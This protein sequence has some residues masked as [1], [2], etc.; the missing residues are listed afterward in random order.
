MKIN[1]IY[2]SGL[3]GDECMAVQLQIWNTPQFQDFD[4]FISL[5]YDNFYNK[6][7]RKDIKPD[8][9]GKFVFFDMNTQYGVADLGKPERFL[10]LC[11]M[12]DKTKY[13]IFPCTN[14]LSYSQCNTQCKPSLAS[15]VF[16]ILGRVECV[17]RIIR[18]EWIPQIIELANNKD[19]NISIWT[20]LERD[21]N[22]N[23]IKKV[24]I[25]YEY[26]GN[27]YVIIL[28]EKKKSKSNTTY[29]EFDTAFP[30]FDKGQKVEFS[31]K[32][33]NYSKN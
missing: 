8:F 21:K 22:G 29:Y 13:P 9:K 2:L 17:Y 16:N 1:L 7:L 6:F 19:K 30:V 15:F 27:D 26:L 14:D 32:Y 18:L 12:E 25:R 28:I 4:E 24:Y 20:D 5:A 10:H 3:Q 11:S 33:K 31:Q 23:R